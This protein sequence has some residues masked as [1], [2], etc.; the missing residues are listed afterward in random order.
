MSII[1]ATNYQYE[2]KILYKSKLEVL[3]KKMNYLQE[4]KKEEQSGYPCMEFTPEGF[5]INIKKEFVR[6]LKLEKA[7]FEG[8]HFSEFISK[9]VL[10]KSISPELW[11]QILNGN[12]ISVDFDV[13]TVDNEKININSFFE[14]IVNKKGVVYKILLK[15]IK[16]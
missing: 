12:K 14:G 3:I 6:F 11:N 4:T 1:R 9:G 15:I 10:S 2:D 5:V 16:W 7:D 13:E 8:L